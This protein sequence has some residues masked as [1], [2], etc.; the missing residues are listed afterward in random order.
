MD[1]D[2]VHG[3]FTDPPV[4]EENDEMKLSY[5]I[6]LHC[7]YTASDLKK[8]P[9]ETRLWVGCGNS[10]SA[11]DLAPGQ[12]VL[13]VG[14]GAA[15]DLFLAAEMVK[16]GGKAVGVDAAG[17]LIDRV[18]NVAKKHGINNIEVFH[19]E[20]E[21]MPFPEGVYNAVISNCVLNMVSN[22]LNVFKEMHR[23][24]KCGG[25]AVI[26]D[27][28]IKKPIPEDLKKELSGCLGFLGS[29]AEPSEYKKWLEQVGFHNISITDKKLD[30]SALYK[31]RKAQKMFC[32][33]KKAANQS[34]LE[35]YDL[36][37]FAMSCTVVAFKK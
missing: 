30:L 11:A 34:V 3:I 23:V 1:A 13:N 22:K 2:P 5:K 28:L 7:G 9:P 16:P 20:L 29:T 26:S 31:D 8:I 10:I 27:I 24:L 25:R 37:E 4:P 14:C 36:N 15:M 32:G 18:K 19:T 12:L 35:K 21:Q 33:S 6:A 17:D